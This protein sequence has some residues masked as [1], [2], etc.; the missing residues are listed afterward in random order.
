VTIRVLIVDDSPV[1]RQALVRALGEDPGLSVV[2]V[3]ANPA[4][5]RRLLELGDHDVVTLDVEMPGMD[6]L[7]FLGELMR[8][9]PTRVVMVSS[10]VRR[11]SQLVLEALRAGAAAVL[12]KPHAGYPLPQMLD[13]L[14]QTLRDVAARPVR[15]VRTGPPALASVAPAVPDHQWIVAVGA[16]TGGTV[17]FETFLRG[18]PAEHPCV[19]LAQHLPDDFVQRFAARLRDVVG[20]E[21]QVARGGERCRPGA[22]FVAPGTHHLRVARRGGELVTELFAGAAVNQHVP[23]ADVLLSSVA[24]IGRASCRERVS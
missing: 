15:P 16:S 12:P 14:R 2:G 24:Q 18:L 19:L 11:S 22:V 20:S 5:A 13:D 9:R 8:T 4:E 7:T 23:S 3:A 6:G 17:A 10:K 1:V 21:V